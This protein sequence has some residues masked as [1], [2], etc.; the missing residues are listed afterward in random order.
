MAPSQLLITTS[1]KIKKIKKQQHP[2][3][4]LLLYR[5]RRLLLLSRY[6][7]ASYKH[8]QNETILGYIYKLLLT[9]IHKKI[10]L[11]QTMLHF[12]IKTQQNRTSVYMVVWFNTISLMSKDLDIYVI[13]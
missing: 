10:V 6:A 12:T 3:V 11:N 2:C 1:Q 4:R 5:R 9:M 8:A 13:S 7:S